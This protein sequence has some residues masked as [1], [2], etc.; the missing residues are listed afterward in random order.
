MNQF[1]RVLTV[2][3]AAAL[4]AA[5]AF[6]GLSAKSAHDIGGQVTSAYLTT[7]QVER[8]MADLKGKPMTGELMNG[9]A[10]ID[11]SAAA[12]TALANNHAHLQP[13][14]DHVRAVLRMVKEDGKVSDKSIGLVGEAS[15]E[16][17]ALMV[18]AAI[19]EAEAHLNSA[20]DALKKDK[21][22]DVVFYLKQANVAMAT[23]NERG[24]YHI[25]NDLEEIEAAVATISDKVSANVP[26][27]AD[28]IEE[29]I[30]EINSHLF[31]VGEGE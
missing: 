28:A 2:T 14:L 20:V 5:P 16:L 19:I 29:R 15:I 26:V 8:Q 18:N 21:R 17:Y 31:H 13:G 9:L 4:F 23:A 25:Q 12:A 27:S 3:L 30:A 11:R 6:A 22:Q 7:T 10:A 1:T 24:A